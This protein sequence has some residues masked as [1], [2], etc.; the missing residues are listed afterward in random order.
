VGKGEG[1]RRRNATG[2][3]HIHTDIHLSPSLSPPPSLPRHH[4]SSS[5]P[6]PPSSP[7]HF[8]EGPVSLPSFLG[9]G[10]H[11]GGRGAAAGEG[12]QTLA[13]HGEAASRGREGGRE[14]GRKARGVWREG[15]RAGWH[16]NTIKSDTHTYTQTTLRILL[17]SLRSARP[18][19]WR[20]W[21]GSRSWW[22]R[23]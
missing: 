9:G 10:G 23:G 19:G 8:R 4:S 16:Q 13:S 12:G 7:L 5:P 1:K 11:E 3:T 18:S 22:W 21:A 14:G 6:S 20:R 15:G 2:R 17:C